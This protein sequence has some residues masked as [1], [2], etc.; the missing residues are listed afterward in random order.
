MN[1]SFFT[2]SLHVAIWLI[3]LNRALTSLEGLFWLKWSC[4]IGGCLPMHIWIIQQNIVDRHA[5]SVR[6]WIK[7]N[8]GWLLVTAF[9]GVIPFTLNISSLL[10]LPE[11]ADFMDG[12]TL[13]MSVLVLA[14][15]AT[16]YSGRRF[17]EH[18]KARRRAAF[19]TSSLAGG[20][21]HHCRRRSWTDGDGGYYAR[22][23]LHSATTLDG[24][25]RFLCG[26]S[27]AITTHRIFD[28][29]QIV[30]VGAQKMI[31]V[32]TVCRALPTYH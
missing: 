3:I 28:A 4:A 6:E 12:A 20:R 9:L 23:P 19:G 16:L 5:T 21:V 2:G 22:P 8:W 11:I 30:L 24:T 15:M 26:D 1:R 17:Q 13:D 31:L 27:F 7:R 25:F 29:R 14:H 32:I 18:Q 10:P